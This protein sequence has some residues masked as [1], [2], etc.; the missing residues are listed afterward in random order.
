MQIATKRRLCEPINAKFQIYDI[1][2]FV[3]LVSYLLLCKQK[4]EYLQEASALWLSNQDSQI[5]FQ[6]IYIVRLI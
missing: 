4:I 2:T 6:I 5:V 3:I 1:T